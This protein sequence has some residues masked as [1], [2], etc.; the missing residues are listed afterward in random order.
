M[1][2]SADL[3]EDY[4]DQ[5]YV[6]LRIRPRR[7]RRILAEA[8]DHLREAAAQGMAAGLTV[9]EAQQE[10]ISAFGSVR[11]VVRAHDSRL[12]RFPAVAVA[13]DLVLAA[14]MLGTFGLLAVGA[15][16]LVAAGMNMLFGPGFVGGTVPAGT[17]LAASAC[18]GWLA[19]NP[20]AHSCAQAAMLEASVDA[21]S[22]RIAA[23]VLGLL[24]LAGYR[25][26]WRD[27]SPGALPEAFVPTVAVSLFG[28]ATVGLVWLAST[29][30][31]VWP[32][33]G[34]GFYLSGAV[35]ALAAAAAFVPQLRRTLLRHARG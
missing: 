34:P 17:K 31:V 6:R 9:R 3:I 12:Q 14:W 1:S 4:L 30:A 18:Q 21:V 7:A 20:G 15:S 19:D 11:A 24:L 8:E 28:A 5:L 33:S 27:P 25:L 16:G 26:V 35:V 22:L 13:R 2:A 29:G 32:S 10:A 23:G